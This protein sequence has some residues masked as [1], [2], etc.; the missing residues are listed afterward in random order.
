LRA[1]LQ[2]ER[3]IGLQQLISQMRQEIDNTANT[4][5]PANPSEAVQVAASIALAAQQRVQLAQL[6]A[7]E[8]RLASRPARLE[9][10]EAEAD[11]LDK[12]VMAAEASQGSLQSLLS[13]RRQDRNA[14]QLAEVKAFAQTLASAPKALRT[15]ADGNIQLAEVLTD[16]VDRRQ[17]TQ[18][19]LKS[20][21]NKMVTLDTK[22]QAINRLL[23]LGQ[24]ESSAAFGAVL[25]QAWDDASRAVE[26]TAIER[27]AGE[28]L[29][30]SR[31]A[32]FYLDEQRPPYTMPT[33]ASLQA[34][35][36]ATPQDWLPSI[37]TLLQ[38]RHRLTSE[39]TRT[40]TQYVDELSALLTQLHDF[41]QRS[42]TY[43]DLLKT[44][45]FW[46]PSAAPLGP[47]TIAAMGDTLNWLL[48]PAHWQEVRQT[49]RRNLTHHPLLVAAGLC[50]LIWLL[51]VRRRLKRRL[52]EIAPSI[53]KV[54]RDRFSLTILA[55]GITTLL[56]LPP[57][58]VIFGLARLTAGPE[59]FADSLSHALFIGG[60]ALLLLEFMLQL[61]RSNGIAEVHFHWNL[62]T[63]TLLRRNNRWLTVIFVPI[64]VVMVLLGVQA[65]PDIRDGLGRFALVTLCFALAV[66]AFRLMR[67]S[68][69][70]VATTEHKTWRWYASYLGYRL[71]IVVPVLLTALSL[72]GFHYTAGQLLALTLQSII[73]VVGAI[74]AYYLLERAFSVYERR[75]AL[76]RLL[77]RRAEHIA[78]NTYRDAAE[79]AGQSIPEM[80]ESHEIDRQTLTDQTK[81]LIRLIVWVGAVL[82]FWSVWRDLVPV[83]QSL[84]QVVLWQV[85]ANDSALPVREVT[86]WQLIVASTMGVMSIIAVKN[87]PG[88]LEIALLSRL[89]LAPGTGY[90]ITTVLKYT[91][92]FFSILAA[93]KLLG[94]DWSKLQWLIAAL[95][96]G[97]GFGLQE[98]VGNFVSGIIILFEK[99]FRLGDTVTIAGQSGTVSR[100]R[101]RATT[102][103]D[104]DRKEHIIPNK[105]FL[106]QDF[107]NWTLTD[108]ITRLI[109]SVGVAYGSDPEQVVDI[110]LDVARRNAKVLDEPPPAALLLSFGDNSLN[111]ELR[112]FTH[113]IL[114][115][116]VGAH[117]LHLAIDKAFREHGIEIAFPQRD[118]H[119][120]STS[121]LEVVLK[122]R[123][124]KPS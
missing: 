122:S 47:Q 66:F 68:R 51:A 64:I 115:R 16:L 95:G 88:A 110:L 59:S 27:A 55:L 45:L 96:V 7:L 6:T 5:P 54:Q 65:S 82:V 4:P 85:A 19:R 13:Q 44:H 1:T 9:L 8:Q 31:I 93:S 28:E 102:I 120:D 108:P 121:P 112:I 42:A 32:L 50:L 61:A 84:D 72:L 69:F 37:K 73:V 76:A 15:L 43:I 80:I 10:M 83:V 21:Q 35:T 100:I 87:L 70:D 103:S 17:T 53:G 57:A 18:E 23:S 78:Q 81:T 113:S 79:R 2:S 63:L 29:T 34:A 97:L 40:H 118:I 39:L 111:F 74:L 33:E 119:L 104:L 90:A 25:R 114:D 20:L 98:I 56:T 101:I 62:P 36:G 52:E 22:F 77:A 14:A 48:T 41:S 26:P 58:M 67:T 89:H 71:L 30:S 117:E 3:N 106:T 124:R 75:L 46:I 94:A 116:I 91:I 12:Q 109:I 107:T 123:D 49:V 99:P 60:C 38:V 24:F 86:L 105:A 92:A 11:L